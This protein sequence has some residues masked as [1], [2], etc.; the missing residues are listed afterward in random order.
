MGFP[1]EG[2]VGRMVSTLEDPTKFMC[3]TFDVVQK[4]N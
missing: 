2:G 3:S 1:I 4:N